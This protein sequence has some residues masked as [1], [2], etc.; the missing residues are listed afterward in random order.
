MENKSHA[1]AAGAFVLAIAALLVAMA[2]WLMRDTSEQRVYEISSKDGVTGLQPQAGVR[3][4]GVLVGR[5][6]SIALDTQ[7]R[8]NVLLRIAVNE[9]AP[10]TTSTFASL[11]FQGVTGLAFVQLDDAA[12]GSPLL[13]TSAAQAARIPMRPGMMS[14]FTSQGGQ[15]LDQLEQAGQRAN[16]LL[17]TDN[18]KNLMAAINNLGQAAA[19]INK[20]TQRADQM[21]ATDAMNLPRV[22]A[23]AD[24]TLKSVQATSE[25]L[26]ASA[27][28]MRTSA[29]EFKRTT[30]RMNEP[31]GTLDK[32]AQGTEALVTTGQALNATLVPRLNRTADDAART[33]RQV[34]RV[35]DT[36][37]DS[38]QS[39]LLGK[40]A[41]QPG[42]GEP[43]FVAPARR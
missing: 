36:L 28:A 38:P 35:A 12:E 22:V 32:I 14:R 30:T 34:G 1:F 16:A 21:L 18:Q 41:S 7:T 10:I 11:G 26:G 13:A 29:T 27:D 3:Y 42:P 17:A 31:G 4:K 25:R 9:T 43:G 6:S 5:V 33:A 40:G 8:G 39:L 24:A 20:L 23:Q 15:L 19:S 37:G 2:A